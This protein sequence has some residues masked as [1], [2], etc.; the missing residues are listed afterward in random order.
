MQC[1]KIAAWC[2]SVRQMWNIN[3]RAIVMTAASTVLEVG[4]AHV[5]H[6]HERFQRA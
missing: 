1:A 4:V 6:A 3:N 2:L 5:L